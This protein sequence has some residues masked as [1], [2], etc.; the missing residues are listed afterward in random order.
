MVLMALIVAGCINHECS[1]RLQ[2][3]TEA[4]PLRLT[5]PVMRHDGFLPL[6]CN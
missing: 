5:H 1:G 3:A 6:W 2:E 4:E